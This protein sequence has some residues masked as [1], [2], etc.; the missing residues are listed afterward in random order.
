MP[1]VAVHEDLHSSLGIDSAERGNA[2]EIA[3]VHRQRCDESINKGACAKPGRWDSTVHGLRI[4]GCQQR[5]EHKAFES[6]RRFGAHPMKEIPFECVAPIAEVLKLHA[7]D[8]L[9]AAETGPNA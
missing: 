5:N 1:I 3:R 4:I 8:K 2:Q 6:G 9:R 7:R